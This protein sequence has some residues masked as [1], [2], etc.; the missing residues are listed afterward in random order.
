MDVI[1]VLSAAHC[2]YGKKDGTGKQWAETH[3]FIVR[4]G[5]IDRESTL[6]QVSSSTIHYWDHNG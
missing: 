1:T 6:G 5:I 4:A 2:F 3:D